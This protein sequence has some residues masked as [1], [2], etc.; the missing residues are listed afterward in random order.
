[1][2]NGTKDDSELIVV[3]YDLIQYIIKEQRAWE[4]F[5]D[6]KGIIRS[7]KSKKDRQ[8]N[9]QW[10]KDKRTDNDRQKLHGEGVGGGGGVLMWT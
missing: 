1:V 9:D 7:R 2:Q 10:K 4:K 8:Y 3:R 6:T 5:E